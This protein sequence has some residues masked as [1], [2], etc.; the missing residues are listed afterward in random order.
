[1][2]LLNVG[3]Y[4]SHTASHPRSRHSSFPDIS[5]DVSH[6]GDGAC[7]RNP[8]VACHGHP[9]SSHQTTRC[10]HTVQGR[11]LLAPP[12]HNSSVSVYRGCRL[13]HLLASPVKK[14]RSQ[15]VTD[16]STVKNV[17]FWDITW[18]G[19][20]KNRRFGGMHR[21]HHQGDKLRVRNS[22]SSNQQPNHAA[23][24]V[25]SYC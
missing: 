17:V 7:H 16:Y 1:M 5:S 6:L 2:L 25:T 20:C 11:L 10:G 3:S 21:L 24:L 9:C 13:A 15:H 4:G 19:P 8:S 23:L 18:C 14:H 12:S 22:V